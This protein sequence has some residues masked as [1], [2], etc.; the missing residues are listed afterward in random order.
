MVGNSGR[1]WGAAYKS[2]D[3]TINPIFL[4]VGTKIS[5][6]TAIEIAKTVCYYRI[7][8]PVNIFIIFFSIINEFIDTAGRFNF[9]GTSQKGQRF[10]FP[11][12][13]LKILDILFKFIQIKTLLNKINKIKSY[14]IL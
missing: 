12:L 8:E 9:K 1:I 7:P 3:V 10:R 2:T 5:L 6:D 11:S 13:K 14:P 4:S